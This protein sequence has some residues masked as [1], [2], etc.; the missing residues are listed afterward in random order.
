MSAQYELNFN[1]KGSGFKVNERAG[2]N[3]G[4]HKLVYRNLLG[5]WSLADADAV[6]TMPVL[7]ITMGAITTGKKGEI[8]LW[9]YIGTQPDPTETPYWAWTVGVP[10][11]ASTVAG[12][13]T[14]TM[15]VGIG[16]VVQI[17]AI[18]IDATLIHFMGTVGASLGGSNTLEGETAFVGFDASKD[19]FVNYYR[20]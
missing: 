3:L 14:E 4:N 1:M 13:L 11:Y 6:A 16:D 5:T 12:E 19:H 15:P 2:E 8:L 9:G 10:L 18:T 17:V 7:G 20:G